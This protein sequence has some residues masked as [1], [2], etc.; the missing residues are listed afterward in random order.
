[1]RINSKRL[2]YFTLIIAK[3]QFGK[4][5]FRRRELMIAVEKALK[6][7]GLWEESDNQQSGSVGIKTKGLARIDWAISILKDNGLTRVYHDTWKVS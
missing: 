7:L 3:A 2:Q 4:D 1:M 5:T 6:E